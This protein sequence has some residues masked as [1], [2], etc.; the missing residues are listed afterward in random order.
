V[1][2]ASLTGVAVG[3]TTVAVGAG[4]TDVAL[5]GVASL[6]DVGEGGVPSQPLIRVRAINTAA[7]R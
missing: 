2:V 3:G 7:N 4:G 6:T 1:G 5:G